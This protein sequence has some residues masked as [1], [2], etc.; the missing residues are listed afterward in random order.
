MCIRVDHQL[1][2]VLPGHYRHMAVAQAV[3]FSGGD[4]QAN[5]RLCCEPHRVLVDE[6]RVSQDIDIRLDGGEIRP[7]HDGFHQGLAVYDDDLRPGLSGFFRQGGNP[8]G[9]DMGDLDP[10]Q[11][12]KTVGLGDFLAD[13]AK[14]SSMMKSKLE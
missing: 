1:G 6:S 2:T 4:L 8:P 7:F 11:D 5:A 13:P 14:P 10:R 3:P 12:K 9:R